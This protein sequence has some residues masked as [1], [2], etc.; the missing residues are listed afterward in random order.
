VW[1][2]VNDF[3]LHCYDSPWNAHLPFAI[4]MVALYPVGIPLLF[5]FL[6]VRYRYKL[7]D[8]EVRFWLGF[9]YDG[10]NSRVYWFELVEIVYKLMMTSVIVFFTRPFMLS[11]GLIVVGVFM[12]ISLVLLPFLS[13]NDDRLQLCAQSVIFLL[14][15]LQQTIDTEG[16]PVPGST[17]DILLSTLLIILTVLLFTL[18]IVQ[19]FSGL[20]DLH[21]RYKR[22]RLASRIVPPLGSSQVEMLRGS[23]TY[24]MA[25]SE[26]S[27]KRDHLELARLPPNLTS[28]DMRLSEIEP[29]SP[30]SL[31]SPSL[32]QTP[33]HSV[34]HA[35]RPLGLSTSES[36]NISPDA[37][38][39]FYYRQNSEE[40]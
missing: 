3:S 15:M 31:Q 33:E 22:T 5:L 7:E 16:A 19:L 8:P 40:A 12:M 29:G 26:T 14:I 28:G 27:E 35:F 10:Y 25:E 18:F 24:S 23:S 13:P 2:L 21:W 6:L 37:S 39:K 4:V 1:Y 20:R 11:G 34:H 38:P 32:P 30:L 36:P 17:I 9:F